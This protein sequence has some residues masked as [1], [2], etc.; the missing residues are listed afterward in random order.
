MQF[1]NE[2]EKIFWIESVRAI[3]LKRNDAAPLHYVGMY[4]EY[5]DMMIGVDE[6]LS[7]IGY[8]KYIHSQYPKSVEGVERITA[9]WEGARLDLEINWNKRDYSYTLSA[10]G[11][12]HVD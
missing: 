2:E 11:V 3:E 12:E 7:G 6:A 5:A 10:A 8:E 9:I 1:R 4:T